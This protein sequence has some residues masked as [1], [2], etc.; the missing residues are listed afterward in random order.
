MI[1]IFITSFSINSAVT[2]FKNKLTSL[3]FYLNKKFPK[4][5][6]EPNPN[7]RKNN[8][9]DHK[10]I[11]FGLG[12]GGSI[13]L[14]LKREYLLKLALKLYWPYLALIINCNIRTI[15]FIGFICSF[16]AIWLILRSWS[17]QCMLSTLGLSLSKKNYDVLI[18]KYSG[19]NLFK[20]FIRLSF[21]ILFLAVIIYYESSMELWFD[22]LDFFILAIVIFHSHIYRWLKIFI[23][24]RVFM[25]KKYM[26][27]KGWVYFFFDKLLAI[28]FIQFTF[29][30]YREVFEALNF[31]YCNEYFV[32]ILLV[33]SRV[34]ILE[35]LFNKLVDFP[36]AAGAAEA[37]NF[38]GFW[39][40]AYSIEIQDKFDLWTR[41]IDWGVPFP[42]GIDCMATFT[43][44]QHRSLMYY[45]GTKDN[46]YNKYYVL[47]TS[48]LYPT[49]F[50]MKFQR[51]S[52]AKY[53][54]PIGD[55]KFHIWEKL[56]ADNELIGNAE[57]SQY[58]AK[59]RNT[60]DKSKDLFLAFNGNVFK[61]DNCM[62]IP[63]NN[64]LY[65]V[66]D[67]SYQ[68]YD[69]TNSIHDNRQMV[70]N[71]KDTMYLLGNNTKITNVRDIE[72]VPQPM[73]YPL[74]YVA[75]KM[76]DIFL[77]NCDK[78][79]MDLKHITYTE[80]QSEILKRIHALKLEEQPWIFGFDYGL[81]NRPI[82]K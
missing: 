25:F 18:S 57:I 2:L 77:V 15:V 11:G 73:F 43:D 16:I 68:L 23:A 46:Y 37:D 21:I 53:L 71:L 81:N 10:T 29:Y 58:I 32:S 59:Y 40:H 66:I 60:N 4:K 20:L 54:P 9:N 35:Y 75:K 64:M 51:Y 63:E 27:E 6:I 80:P 13:F 22:L 5:G 44:N 61:V 82:S 67:N 56:N 65:V 72:I 31:F 30:T 74:I 3:F 36:P 17:L 34:N 79:N 52:D 42:L 69:P 28:I 26:V 41:L 8:L 76:D 48:A 12:V 38:K 49:T 62:D 24:R 50:E 19:L 1:V 39:P 7:N 78:S 45:L 55:K 14:F 70:I 47:Q 33:A